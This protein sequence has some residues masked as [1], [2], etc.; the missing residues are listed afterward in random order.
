VKSTNVFPVHALNLAFI[1]SKSSEA[2][3]SDTIEGGIETKKDGL[4]S[5]IT[6]MRASW[7]AFINHPG[8]CDIFIFYL[9]ARDVIGHD[10]KIEIPLSSPKQPQGFGNNRL[11]TP[12]G[13][14]EIGDLTTMATM[15]VATIG[16]VFF[17]AGPLQRAHAVSPNDALKKQ[18]QR[19]DRALKLFK[20]THDQVY[21]TRRFP[22]PLKSLLIRVLF[23]FVVFQFNRNGAAG[24]EYQ[25]VSDAGAYAHALEMHLYAKAA[26]AFVGDVEDQQPVPEAGFIEPLFRMFLKA[27][28][29]VR[30]GLPLFSAFHVQSRR[31][32][33][34]VLKSY[35]YAS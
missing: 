2:S 7:H 28:F 10:W 23:A 21:V 31:M 5:S 27:G 34:C 33:L 12:N 25:P 26:F 6:R 22:L 16:S 11:L 29:I 1:F 24:N 8:S 9:L 18:R 35:L 14:N 17:I 19:I 32:K 13:I 15:C 20:R 3:L 30:D 4:W